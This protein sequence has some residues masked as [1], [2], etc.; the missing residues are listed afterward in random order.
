MRAS[1]ALYQYC[2]LVSAVLFYSIEQ[3]T[4]ERVRSIR[5]YL[6]HPVNDVCQYRRRQSIRNVRVSLKVFSSPQNQKLLTSMTVQVAV[7][8]SNVSWDIY[9]LCLRNISISYIDSLLV[10]ASGS[11]SSLLTSASNLLC[12]HVP[13]HL[14]AIAI[15]Q[16]L[17]YSY[18]LSAL[19]SDMGC[20][21]R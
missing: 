18:F 4:I 3:Y 7:L 14:A 16:Q 6:L 20:R 21:L 15:S 9:P 2:L 12:A 19:K 13:P 5:A 11:T 8:V 10:T 17:F 1:L